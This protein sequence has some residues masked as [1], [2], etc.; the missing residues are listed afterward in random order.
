MPTREEVALQS[1]HRLNAMNVLALCLTNYSLNLPKDI[2]IV[3]NIEASLG[4]HIV[5]EKALIREKGSSYEVY[6]AC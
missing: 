5:K 2:F 3:E 6:K 1:M 4:M